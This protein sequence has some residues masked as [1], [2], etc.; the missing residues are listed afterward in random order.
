MLYP[1][2]QYL[3]KRSVCLPLSN[4]KSAACASA[5]RLPLPR[6]WNVRAVMR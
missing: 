3:L 4:S 1:L 2:F 5:T 6:Q